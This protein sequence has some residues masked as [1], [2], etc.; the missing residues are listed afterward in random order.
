[1]AARQGGT[2]NV[3]SPVE[4]WVEEVAR[5]TRPDSIHWCDGSDAENI[6]LTELLQSRHELIKLNEQAQPNS[7]LYRSDPSDV[8]RTER[9]TFIVTDSQDQVGPTN[10]WMS[11]DDA[12]TRVWP[13]FNGCMQGRTMYVIPYLMGPADSPYSKVG[14]EITDSAYVVLNMRIMTRIGTLAMERLQRDGS[15]WVPGIHSVGDLSPDRRFIVHF[16]DTRTIWSIGSG[17]GGNALLGK[18]CFSLRIAST[19]GRTQGWMAEHMLILGLEAP[20]GDVTY[21]CGAFPSACGKT[22]LA[23][24]KSP[25]EDQ[26]WKVHTVGEDIAWLNIGPDGRLWAI[27]PEAGYFGVAP[28]TNYKTN[29]NAMTAIMRDTIFTNV[30]LKDDGTVWWEGMDGPVPEHLIDWL[31]NDWEPSDEAMP[32]AAHPNSRF[33]TPATNN[34]AISSHWEDPRGVPIS[35]ILFGGRRADTVPLVT[36]SFDWEHGVYMGA[37]MASEGTA[38]AETKVGVVRRDPMAM[39]PFCGYN[40]A[41][42]WA[43]WLEMGRRAQNPPAIFQVN[44]FQRDENGK[45]IW[46][47]F[48]QNMRVLRWVREQ[49]L[50]GGGQSRETPI[51]VVPT[52]DAIGGQE[53][54]IS[55]KHMEQ[56]LSVDHE[57]WATEVA[58]QK[59]FLAKFGDRLPAEIHKQAEALERRVGKVTA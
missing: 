15:D 21:I 19:M 17:Y 54:G 31:G 8:A 48:G 5:T 10:N 44:W 28:G 37:T 40:M 33:T 55:P 42:Y 4:Q 53:L 1:M 49:A 36:Q 51:G 52:P 26:G 3:A 22:N 41:D 34:P 58:A 11:H 7:Y 46:P 16:P 47:G 13:L 9:L 6:R 59:Q 23:M 45:F 43:H 29:P 27:N 38:A 50:N 30:A 14:V 57:L 32:P 25:F 39:L 18:K 20:D 12:N 24:L 35:A 56:V 2:S